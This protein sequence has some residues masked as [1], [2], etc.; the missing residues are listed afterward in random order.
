MFKITRDVP[1]E[2]LLGKQINIWQARDKLNAREKELGAEPWHSGYITISRLCGS[3]GSEIA[4][5]IADL[6]NWQI[7]DREVVHEIANSSKLRS[8]VV[9]SLNE[10]QQEKMAAWLQGVVDSHQLNSDLY[11]EHLSRVI[12]TIATH[13]RSVIIGR[14]ANFLL[15]TYRGVRVKIYAPQELRIKKIENRDKITEKES[16]NRIRETDNRRLAFIRQYFHRDADDPSF[17]DLIINTGEICPELAAHLIK[18]TLMGKYR[19]L[20]GLEKY[21]GSLFTTEKIK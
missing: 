12:Y 4:S 1:I 17:Y 13:G 7:F 19:T 9:D 5:R 18:E 20:L 6:L 11:L 2:H 10:K 15:E 8:Q 16:A 21:S 14:G 3:G